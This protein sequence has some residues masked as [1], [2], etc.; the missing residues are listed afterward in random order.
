MPC[1]SCLC[2]LVE[3]T[4]YQLGFSTLDVTTL[5]K[6][7]E[8][9]A[10]SAGEQSPTSLCYHPSRLTSRMLQR[11]Y[12]NTRSGT[13]PLLDHHWQVNSSTV[14]SADATTPV[15]AEDRGSCSSVGTLMKWPSEDFEKDG[16]AVELPPPTLGQ[17]TSELTREDYSSHECPRRASTGSA[18]PVHGSLSS[19]SSVAVSVAP[20]S[21]PTRDYATNS[22]L[23]APRKLEERFRGRAADAD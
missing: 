6:S 15:V 10:S 9:H 5:R 16:A 4:S 14:Q 8:L 20:T 17:R 2:A 3:F 18:L 21:V 11:P 1:S 12:S 13:N 23:R 22:T 7:I 19:S